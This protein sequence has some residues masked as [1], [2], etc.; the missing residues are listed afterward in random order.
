M[1]ARPNLLG[2]VGR[3]VFLP[4]AS[5]LGCFF[6]SNGGRRRRQ[7]SGGRRAAGPSTAMETGGG[8]AEEEEQVMS[9]VHLGCPP[10]FSGLHISRFSFSSRP[11]G[12]S[13]SCH[14]ARRA[15][16]HTSPV[17]CLLVLLL[18]ET[19]RLLGHGGDL[20]FA[21]LWFGVFRAVWGQRR[22]CWRRERASRSNER[23][24]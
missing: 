1:F 7:T 9:E 11:L 12:T 24:L 8:G 10:H 4:A 16:R 21:E 3:P 15:F 14:A 5:L 2:P 13:S 19:E 20:Y 18:A 23:F 22:R 6:L 17:H